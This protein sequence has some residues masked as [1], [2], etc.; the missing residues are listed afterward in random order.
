M[1]GWLWEPTSSLSILLVTLQRCKD[2]QEPSL[3]LCA[4]DNVI[5]LDS[6]PVTHVCQRKNTHKHTIGFQKTKQNHT[7]KKKTKKT[8]NK[9]TKTKTKKP[10]HTN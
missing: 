6:L 10:T 5:W 4:S 3:T 8:K 9:Q 7:Q 1:S 2:L